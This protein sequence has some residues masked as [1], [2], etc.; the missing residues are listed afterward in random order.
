MQSLQEGAEGDFLKPRL[1]T[2]PADC[3][4]FSAGSLEGKAWGSWRSAP[5]HV[6]RDALFLSE[7]TKAVTGGRELCKVFDE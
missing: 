6:G 4:A 2:A 5:L 3:F 7:M 1:Q